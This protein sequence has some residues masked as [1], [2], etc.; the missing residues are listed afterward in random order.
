[1]SNTMQGHTEA[2]MLHPKSLHLFLSLILYT[3]NAL[4]HPG[5]YLFFVALEGDFKRGGL[6]ERGQNRVF[7]VSAS[8]SS[9]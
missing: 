3:A 7:M 4:L 2:I 9:M 5:A 8:P 1:M 6:L